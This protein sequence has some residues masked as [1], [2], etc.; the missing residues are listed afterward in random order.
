VL[1][2]RIDGNRQG[3]SLIGTVNIRPDARM[4]YVQQEEALVGV[5]T[6][7]ETLVFAARLAGAPLSRTD[8]LLSEMGTE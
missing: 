2:T 7:R 3:R 8:D 5:L 1:A 6:V 4:R